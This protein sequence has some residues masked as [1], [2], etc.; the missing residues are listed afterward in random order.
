MTAPTNELRVRWCVPQTVLDVANAVNWQV[1]SYPADALA[2]GLSMLVRRRK[3]QLPAI[4][5]ALRI[6]AQ[7]PVLNVA[8]DVPQVIVD[9]FNGIDWTKVSVEDQYAMAAELAEF[10]FGPLVNLPRRTWR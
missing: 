6:P 1:L 4:T 8:P 2:E 9:V 3:K 5:T 7:P 10:V